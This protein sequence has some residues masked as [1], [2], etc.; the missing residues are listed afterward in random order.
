MTQT[1]DAPCKPLT[2]DALMAQIESGRAD[3]AMAELQRRYRAPLGRMIQG[4]VHDEWFCQDLLQEVF[5]KVFCKSHLYEQ[6][7]NF[8][9]WLFG[10]ARNHALSGLRRRRLQ[11]QPVTAFGDPAAILDAYEIGQAVLPTQGVEEEEFLAAF[12]Q[13]VA[14]LPDRYRVIF[15][16]CVVEGETYRHVAEDMGIPAGTVAI[17]ISRARRRL[18]EALRRHLGDVVDL[19]AC[20][21]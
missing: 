7:T 6:G 14:E 1:V 3:Q 21:R 11:P 2:D 4:V 13:A 12:R 20:V 5:V 17:R 18:F 10:V 16:R 9:A 8:R 15:E 19:P